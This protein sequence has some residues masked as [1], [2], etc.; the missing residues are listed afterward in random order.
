MTEGNE[1]ALFHRGIDLFNS[2]EFFDCHEVFEELWTFSQ[3]PDRWF[4]QALIHF[5]VGFYHAGRSN[6]NG[7]TRQLRKGL[8]KI[9]GYLPEWDGV[10]TGKIAQ[11]VEQ[12]LREIEAGGTV[13][14]YPRIVM[15]SAW[16]GLRS[17]LRKCQ[18]NE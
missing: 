16:P 2:R 10:E 3:Q 14:G 4:L 6:P 11:A 8:R 12:R 15:S 9:Q 13:S 7:A 1:Q 17:P 5:A 18:G